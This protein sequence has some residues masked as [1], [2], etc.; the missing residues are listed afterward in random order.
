MEGVHSDAEWDGEERPG[1]GGLLGVQLLKAG[2]H[3]CGER[4]LEQ[5]KTRASA[6]DV[7]DEV[8]LAEA[9]VQGGGGV[10][11]VDRAGVKLR[12]EVRS[13]EKLGGAAEPTLR[14]GV[15]APAGSSPGGKRGGP[16]FGAAVS[17]REAHVGRGGR[18]WHVGAARP[19]GAWP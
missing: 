18:Q 7:T 10:C 6:W 3:F 13:G 17:R 19:S 1:G 12:G 9:Q 16:C 2:Q 8:I 15:L 11:V 14:S 4:R 5:G